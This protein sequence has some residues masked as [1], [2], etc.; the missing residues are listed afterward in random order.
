M[1]PSRSSSRSKN[2]VKYG[3]EAVKLGLL[4]KDCVNMDGDC[5][6]VVLMEYAYVSKDQEACMPLLRQFF[7]L[8]PC[9]R[10]VWACLASSAFCKDFIKFCMSFDYLYT[11][12]VTIQQ[13]WWAMPMDMHDKWSPC[14]VAWIR[15][16]VE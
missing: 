13:Y 1:R 4:D 14:R 5:L 10:K 7:G 15:A 16:V 6:A 3:L 2:V 12:L 9:L 8:K 11:D